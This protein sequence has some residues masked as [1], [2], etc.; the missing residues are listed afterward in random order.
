M[1]VPPRANAVP[2]NTA[3]TMP[4]QRD[5]QLHL[6][7]E[8]GRTAWQEASGYNRPALVEADVSRFK[9]VIGN[10]L[11]SRRTGLLHLT[12]PN[13]TVRKRPFQSAGMR[14]AL[15]PAF[16]PLR[17]ERADTASDMRRQPSSSMSND[18]AMD[19]RK[20]GESP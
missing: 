14:V 3:E 15:S 19:M 13:Q 16:R 6:L 20:N 7:A 11:R 12:R 9:R 18:V 4:M 10:A 1:V 17:H 8:Q 5:R 2:S